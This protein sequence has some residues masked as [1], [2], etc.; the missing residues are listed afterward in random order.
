MND[1]TDTPVEKFHK[2]IVENGSKEPIERFDAVIETDEHYIVLGNGYYSR[3][4]FIILYY[5]DEGLNFANWPISQHDT[6]KEG[7]Y[8]LADHYKQILLKQLR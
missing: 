6:R 1:I 8:A 5:K 3:P 4:Y 2:L 7:I